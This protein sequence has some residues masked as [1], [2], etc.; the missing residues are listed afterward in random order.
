[1]TEQLNSLRVQISTF[2]EEKEALEEELDEYV[3]E[4]RK[5]KEILSET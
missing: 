5:L 1:M 2:K 3:K 4:N